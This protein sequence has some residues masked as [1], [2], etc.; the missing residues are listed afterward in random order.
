[1]QP[2]REPGALRPPVCGCAGA[3]R[4]MCSGHDG[5]GRS[6]CMTASPQTEDGYLMIAN[7]LM[8]AILGFGFSL[9]EQSV[10]F[11]IIRKTYG[12]RKKEDDISASQIGD[13]CNVAR[14][15]VTSTLNL[16]AVRRV[17]TKR[18]GRFGSIIGVQKDHR[19]WVTMQHM[20]SAA[21]SPDLGQVDYLEDGENRDS[22]V[23]NQ[24]TCPE[25]GHVPNQDVAS[26]NSGH[27]L[28]P[29]RDTQKTT[30]KDN[31]QKKRSCAPQAERE[32]ESRTS[33]G[34]Q[35]RATTGSSDDLQ[36]RFARFYA[37]YPRKKS[38]KA[39]EKAFAKL[40]PD[41]QLLADILSSLERAMTSG[42]WTDPQFIP[43]P[44]SWLGAEGW[45]DEI[46]VE[47]SAC[48]QAVI[49]FFNDALGEQLGVVPMAPFVGARAA[50]IRSFVTFSQKPGFTERYF[51]WVRD[52]TSLPPGVG[53]DFLIS[54]KGF[55]NATSGQH[56]RKAK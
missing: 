53:F 1:M 3:S 45:R 40:N 50:A 56:E 49:G 43:Y 51:P 30:S 39:A 18:P 48:E 5:K 41:E 11:T 24:D 32:S 23:P 13:M 26:P 55:S 14:Q 2:V 31:Q 54:R 17:I 38:R 37:A 47:Y 21:A 7:E 4:R 15:H 44:A 19:K 46:Q 27:L 33:A 52:N 22:V 6:N 12:F 16:L 35:G 9:R 8:E 25:L 34:R 29:I 36:N 10:L 28:V 20:R 42:E